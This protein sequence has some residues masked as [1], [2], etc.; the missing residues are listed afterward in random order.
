MADIPEKENDNSAKMR[1]NKYLSDAGYCSRREADR[2]IEAG[3]VSVDGIPA[4]MGQKVTPGQRVCVDGNEIVRTDP[5][6]LIA[7]NKPSGIECTSDLSNPDNIISYIGYPSRIYPIGRLDKMS[8]GLILLTNNGELMND[9]LKSTG[10]HEKE[11]EVEVDSPVTDEFIRRM[12]KG[13]DISGVDGRGGHVSVNSGGSDSSG[14]S[15]EA[16][17]DG[18]QSAKEMYYSI[19]RPCTVRRTGERTFSIILTQGLNRQIRRMCQALGY[20]V[21]SLHRTRI[22]GVCLDGL[23][24]GAYRDVTVQ[25][26]Y[27]ESP[28]ES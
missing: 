27:G 1:L 28:S 17:E 24:A 10:Y 20:R 12:S 11:Y 25:E 7:F 14:S 18:Q 8:T 4:V 21:V 6:V 19:T 9:I 23:Q 15:E 2:L 26:L 22:M 16:A 3:H 5:M 13:V